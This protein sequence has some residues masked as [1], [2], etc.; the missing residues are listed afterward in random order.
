MGLRFTE[1]TYSLKDGSRAVDRFPERDDVE[2]LEYFELEIPPERESQH[3][4]D[5]KADHRSNA[6]VCRKARIISCSV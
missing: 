4:A 1:V 3:T 5:K 2:H 6:T